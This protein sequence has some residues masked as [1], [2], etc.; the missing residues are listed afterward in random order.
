MRRLLLL[1]TMLCGFVTHS[2]SQTIIRVIMGRVSASPD[3]TTWQ[4]AFP[5]L[6]PALDLAATLP[7]S[8]EIWVGGGEYV[9][10]QDI[11]RTVTFTIPANTMLYG[12]FGGNEATRGL[13]NWRKWRT[14]LSGDLGRQ[15]D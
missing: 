3:G 14:A 11:N 12:G 15:F 10:T 2:Q 13:R 4:K 9:P 7:G 1:I 5:D 6:K 8:K